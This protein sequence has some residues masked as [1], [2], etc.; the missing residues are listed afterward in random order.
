MRRCVD[1]LCR[2]KQRD[3]GPRIERLEKRV[4]RG[5][6]RAPSSSAAK[7]RSPGRQPA[8]ELASSSAA[9]LDK[10][11]GI[12]RGRAAMLPQ[13]IERKSMNFPKSRRERG[14]LGN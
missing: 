11:Q 10:Y 2:C 5:A 9:A 1:L 7:V 13:P 14:V 8:R 12:Y 3:N 6:P 4:R